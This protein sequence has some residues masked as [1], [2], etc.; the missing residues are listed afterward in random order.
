MKPFFAIVCVC[1]YVAHF[2]KFGHIIQKYIKLNCFNKI[3]NYSTALIV[4][5]L[6]AILLSISITFLQDASIMN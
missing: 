5:K 2:S 6:N 1:V 3:F 4:L